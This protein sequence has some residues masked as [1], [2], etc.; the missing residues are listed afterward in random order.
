MSRAPLKAIPLADLRELFNTEVL[1]KIEQGQCLPVVRVDRDAHPKY[2]EPVGTRSQMVE[3]W[4][5]DSG[6]MV[7]LAF[8]HRFLRPDGSIGA[9]GQLDPKIVFSKGVGY[10]PLSK[11]SGH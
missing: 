11:P 4:A 5:T 6:R 7:K 2:N 10:K 1:P 9:S 8:V 3:F